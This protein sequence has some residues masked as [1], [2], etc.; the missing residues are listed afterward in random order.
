[1]KLEPA[2]FSATG[3][4][5]AVVDGRQALPPDPRALANEL[6]R[7]FELDG[8]L[9]AVRPRTGGDCRMLVH[10][11]DG[12]PAETSGNGLRCLARWAVEHGLVSGDELAIETEAGTRRA[13]LLRERDAGRPAGP[14]GSIW[15]ARV[16]MGT[17]GIV[18]REVA[19]ECGGEERCLTLVDM[20]NPHGVLFVADVASSPVAHLGA[21]LERHARF[22]RG[23]NI[24]F[25]EVVA[26]GGVRG[27]GGQTTSLLH[28]RT[29]ERGVGETASCGSG[30][31]ASAAAAI[32]LGRASSPVAIETRG[33][34]LEVAW[35]GL[36]TLAL[37]G[38]VERL[39]AAR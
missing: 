38:P 33:G 18:E 36:G 10:N 34:T 37:A 20:G 31:S 25:V 11:K 35:D 39:A 15:G 7:R 9:L 6:C 5:F 12:S 14:A 3:N 19:L 8:L 23:A 30:V 1:M 17:P 29:W 26:P 13:R 2:L 27:P 24:S 16:E 22:R 28:V 4:R 32:A 21:A